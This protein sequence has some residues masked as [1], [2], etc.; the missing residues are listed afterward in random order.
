[1]TFP[2]GAALALHGLA[3]EAGGRRLLTLPALALAPGEAL[4]VNGPSGAGKS[5]LL[6]ALAGLIP[7]SA[8]RIVWGGD[9]ITAMNAPARARWRRRRVGLVFQDHQLFDEMTALDNAALSAAYAPPSERA[10]LRAGAEGWLE[11]LGLG[12]RLHQRAATLSGGERQRV[13]IARA[14]AADPEVLLADEPTASLDRAAADRLIADLAGLAG[15][16]TLVAVTHDA[17]LTAALGRRLEIRDG[18]PAAEPAR[19]L[20]EVPAHA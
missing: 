7:A 17:A 6:Y 8:G 16:R 2:N 13:S 5:T 14:L 11:R 12:N 3:I 1:M 15:T 10:A 18:A 4:A 19:P 9:E 20:A